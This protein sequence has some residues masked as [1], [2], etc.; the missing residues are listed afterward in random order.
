[1]KADAGKRKLNKIELDVWVFNEFAIEFYE[2][3]GLKETR[4]WMEYEL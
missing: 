3:M 2:A 4:I 1:M